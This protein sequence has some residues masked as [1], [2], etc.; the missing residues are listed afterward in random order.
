MDNYFFR[1]AINKL[2][3]DVFN[4][5]ATT[6]ATKSY[7]R[8]HLRRRTKL[9]SMVA[10]IDNLHR[11]GRLKGDTLAI[12]IN[13]SFRQSNFDETY[14]Y[15]ATSDSPEHSASEKEF[16]YAEYFRWKIDDF[17]DNV[18]YYTVYSKYPN[19]K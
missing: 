3:K 14:S 15:C 18:Y 4:N 10:D 7:L 19:P 1:G 12:T 8:H 9:Q 13:Q 17:D 16:I 6:K 2:S 5:T 11:T